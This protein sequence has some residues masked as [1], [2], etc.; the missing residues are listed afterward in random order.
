MA[1]LTTFYV[2]KEDQTTSPLHWLVS[3]PGEL[4]DFS[5][6]KDSEGQPLVIKDLVCKCCI[7]TDGN[8]GVLACGFKMQNQYGGA[9]R[10]YIILVD[11]NTKV[12]KVIRSFIAIEKT[13]MLYAVN[14]Y[15]IN[16]DT[17]GGN[18]VV[19][20]LANGKVVAAWIAHDQFDFL[21]LLV[22]HPGNGLVVIVSSSR[23]RA[24][25]F[26]IVVPETEMI[27]RLWH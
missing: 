17:L 26:K 13:G 27:A 18:V 19:E 6:M 24:E 22:A 16:I 4:S 15:C 21:P 11:F 1:S 12:T 8:T 7:T 9:S 2:L 14:I 10:S 20:N 3:N 5:F 23:S 25:F